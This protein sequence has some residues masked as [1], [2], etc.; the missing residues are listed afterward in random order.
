MRK[1]KE[2]LDAKRLASR[3]EVQ[4]IRA[5]APIQCWVE[6]QYFK[7]SSG[8]PEA[9]WVV[10]SRPLPLTEGEEPCS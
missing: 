9:I 3:I 6:Q 1:T 10:R 4:A 5:G 7:L 8:E 2:E